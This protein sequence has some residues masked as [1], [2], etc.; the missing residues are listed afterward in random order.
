[1]SIDKAVPNSWKASGCF[2]KDKM[3]AL[4]DALRETIEKYPEPIF[5]FDIFVEGRYP[6]QAREK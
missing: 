3:L 6:I 1:M 5:A 4:I 2:K